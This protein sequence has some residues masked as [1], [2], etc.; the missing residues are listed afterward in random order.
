MRFYL[1]FRFCDQKITAS[2][3]R[4]VREAVVPPRTR[5]FYGNGA[6]TFRKIFKI[7]SDDLLHK[8]AAIEETRNVKWRFEV[9]ILTTRSRLFEV[10]LM[11][12]RLDDIAAMIVNAN[13]GIM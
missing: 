12:V 8:V 3:T 10:A 13:H 4:Q 5:L 9:L 11:L 6:T 1:S 7:V 2:R